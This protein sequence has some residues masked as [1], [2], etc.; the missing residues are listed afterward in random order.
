MQATSLKHGQSASD[1][2]LP[3]TLVAGKRLGR[4]VKHDPRSREFPADSASRV[5][6][7]K[8]DASALPLDQEDHHCSTAHSLCGALNC[9]INSREGVLY[10]EAD[11]IRVFRLAATLNGDDP[12]GRPGSSGLMACKAARDLGLIQEYRHAFGIDHAL[13]ALVLRPVMTGIK[14]YSSFDEPD[15]TT[16]LVE[17]A[18][19]A[20]LR[21]GHEVLVHEIDVE[22]GLVWCWNSWGSR[23]GLGGRFCMSFDTWAQ[24]LGDDGDVTVPIP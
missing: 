15:P 17:L 24:L 1:I 13:H 4:H 16:G 23:F 20:V 18:E 22:N 7:V 2:R 8:H 19:S 3:E 6:S 9:G 12:D 11:A 10:R 21:G 14:W 5:V